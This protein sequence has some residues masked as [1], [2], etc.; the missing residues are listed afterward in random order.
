MITIPDPR[1]QSWRGIY[2]GQFHGDF[3]RAQNIDLEKVPGRLLLSDRVK[4]LVDDSDQADLRN[5]LAFVSSAADGSG[6][7]WWCLADSRVLST[8]NLSTTD[9]VVDANTNTPTSTTNRG[10]YDIIEFIDNTAKQHLL[11]TGIKDSD[12]TTRIFELGTSAG[13]WTANWLSISLGGFCAMGKLSNILLLTNGYKIDTVDGNLNYT[14]AR[15]TLDSNYQNL[16]IYCGRD[17]AW[18]MGRSLY[19]NGSFGAGAGDIDGGIIY[20]WDGGSDTVNNSYRTTSIPLSGFIANDLPYF[21]TRD[22]RILGFTGSA[23]D[24]VAFFPNYEENIPF[25]LDA[26][27]IRGITVEGDD[28]YINIKAPLASDGMRSG[29][30]HFNTKTFNLYPMYSHSQCKTTNKDFGQA[31]VSAVG[32]MFYH[33]DRDLFFIGATVYRA[34]TSTLRYAIQTV[35]RNDA[36]G[37]RGYFITPSMPSAYVEDFFYQVWL[38]FPLL[39]S[40]INKIVCKYTSTDGLVNSSYRPIQLSMTWVDTTHFTCVL[41]AGI[42]TGNEVE[43]LSGDNAGCLFHISAL[44]ATPDGIATI[45]VTI[46][47]AAPIASTA[48]A[49]A[50]F[51]NWVKITTNNPI[52]SQTIRTQSLVMGSPAN[53]AGPFISLKIE[54]RGILTGI[55]QIKIDSDPHITPESG[56][57][58]R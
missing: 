18:I 5:P 6:G 44:S 51:N 30:W 35:S 9:F 4:I 36:L 46:D 49:F 24:A 40:N 41:P 43:V 34:Y 14:S 57:Q 37:N 50:E 12:S 47:E 11:V 52:T 3:I 33:R 45:T 13:T 27:R 48:I 25:A 58:P 39:R 21:V 15:L 31:I 26:C 42:V 16:G 19:E 38:K 53:A 2:P 23:F 7:R 8:T 54:L 22:G 17:R 1:K 20:E 10:L 29:V 28:V 32:G 55:D 56:P